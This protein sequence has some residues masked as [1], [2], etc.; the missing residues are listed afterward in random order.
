MRKEGVIIRK[1]CLNYFSISVYAEAEI[2]NLPRKKAKVHYTSPNS[3]SRKR[4]SIITDISFAG[5]S[6]C[7]CLTVDAEDECY[8]IGDFVTTHNCAKSYS[9]A[10]I[11]THN[12]ELGESETSKKRVTTVLTAYQKEYLKDD[13]DGTLSKFRPALSFI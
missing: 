5:Y 13:K 11:M 9:L 12:L 8:L 10:S 3:L 1:N 7:K 6:M 2:F 4:G